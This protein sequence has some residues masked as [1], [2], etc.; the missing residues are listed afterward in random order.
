MRQWACFLPHMRQADRQQLQLPQQTH[1]A[2]AISNEQPPTL[3]RPHLDQPV[4]QEV[5]ETPH[6]TQPPRQHN[7][8]PSTPGRSTRLVASYKQPAG[9]QPHMQI[10]WGHSH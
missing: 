5:I 2:T 3:K 1:D 8:A 9:K 10:A 4:G 6:I 7:V